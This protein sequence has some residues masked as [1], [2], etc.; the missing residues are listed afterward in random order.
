MNEQAVNR[1]LKAA[2]EQIRVIRL[3]KGGLRSP[4]LLAKKMGWTTRQK[5]NYYIKLLT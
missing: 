5:A 2:Y 4:T 3:I 1:M